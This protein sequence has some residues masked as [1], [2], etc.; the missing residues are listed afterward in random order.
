MTF[1]DNAGCG[2]IVCSV[3]EDLICS[4]GLDT[5]RWLHNV[6]MIGSGDVRCNVDTLEGSG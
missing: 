3:E 5:G 4:V 2:L 6:L 1:C